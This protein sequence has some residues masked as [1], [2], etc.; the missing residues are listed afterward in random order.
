MPF[1]VVQQVEAFIEPRFGK[2]PRQRK[3]RCL[4]PQPLFV[5]FSTRVVE[6]V[7]GKC[8]VRGAIERRGF[9]KPWIAPGTH[10]AGEL[11]GNDSAR[12]VNQSFG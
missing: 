4:K 11:A 12:T 1:D 9:N 2:A 8:T 7:F 10:N 3:I 5:F 6:F